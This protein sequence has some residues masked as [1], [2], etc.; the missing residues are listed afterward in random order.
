MEHAGI[1]D[2]KCDDTHMLPTLLITSAIAPPA[3]TPMLKMTNRDMRAITTKA[4]I[5][6]WVGQGQ[7]NIVVCDSTGSRVL[8]DDEL[9]SI[10]KVGVGIEQIA[11]Q[12][13]D[14][15]VVERG[16]AFAEGQLIKFALDNS[17]LLI[18]SGYFFKCT[19]KMFCRNFAAIWDLIAKNNI[20]NM[21]W[22]LYEHTLVDRNLV[23]PRFFYTSIVDFHRFVLP[24]YARSSESQILEY[25]LSLSL[26]SHLSR[27]AGR[28]PLLSGFSGGL[29]DQCQ[30]H[31]LGDLDMNYP[32]W[33]SL[34]QGK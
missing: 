22:K 20:A 2:G 14:A 18:R 11:Y 1:V 3:N 28:R 30:E 25:Q 17:E 24:A 16:K 7:K 33:Y 4:A 9:S 5:F 31:Y 23:D 26:N 15:V 19:G 6:F 10:R 12:Q 34:R 27:G 13:D 29:G 21:F 32:C 8:N